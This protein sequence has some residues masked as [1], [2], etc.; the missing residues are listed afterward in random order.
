MLKPQMCTRWFMAVAM[1]S[2][3]LVFAGNAMGS[4]FALIAQSASGA[5]CAYA[6]IGVTAPC[7]LDTE[8]SDGWP[9]A[10]MP[11]N[12]NWPRS[13]STPP[14]TVAHRAFP[15]QTASG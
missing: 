12:P 2:G 8:C 1:V 9:A 5:G 4:G 11:S 13:T 6:G 14:T 7:G 10:A 15:G 3:M